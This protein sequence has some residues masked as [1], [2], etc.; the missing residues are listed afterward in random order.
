MP[1]EGRGQSPS[2]GLRHPSFKR[3]VPESDAG[4]VGGGLRQVEREGQ[5]SFQY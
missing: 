5:R 4:S 3:K 1:G 2:T